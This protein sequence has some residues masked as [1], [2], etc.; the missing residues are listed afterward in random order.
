M[1]P[2]PGDASLAPLAV[3]TL[4]KDGATLGARLAAELRADFFVHTDADYPDGSTPIAQRFTRVVEL[5]AQ[6]FSRY[7]GLIY[8]MPTGVVVRSIAPLLESKLRDPAIVALDVCARYAISLLSGH[9]G[10]AN[11][12]AIQVANHTGAEPIITT[13][14]DVRKDI[15]AGIGCRKNTQMQAIITALKQALTQA[16][17]TLDAV[18]LL[19]TAQVKASE[20]GL[21]QAAKELDIPLRIISD[22]EI[23]NCPFT[24]KAS[25]FVQ[26]KVGLPGVCEPAALL[27]GRRAQFILRKTAFS[28][29]TI[30]LAREGCSK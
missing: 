8:I 24:L 25:A 19:A 10:G 27:A 18:R 14:T 22:E 16:E 5:S 29:V 20:P 21:L 12:L 15:I 9:E 30:A 26:D 11:A 4:S 28:G 3:I 1:L 13:T 23:R 2:F 6:I 17:V 7:M